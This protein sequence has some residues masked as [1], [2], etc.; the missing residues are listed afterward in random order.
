MFVF[1]SKEAGKFSVATANILCIREGS[2]A[3]PKGLL[4]SWMVFKNKTTLSNFLTRVY[5]WWGKR[6]DKK[7][8]KKTAFITSHA[9][10]EKYRWVN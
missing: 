3:G 2:G 6:F 7:K 8:Q 9:D 4:T 1:S 5:L 10:V